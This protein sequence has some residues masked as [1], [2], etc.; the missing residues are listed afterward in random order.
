MKRAEVKVSKFILV[1]AD[2][3]SKKTNSA[4]KSDTT[5]SFQER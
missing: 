4:N 1:F 3:G 5:N 2:K